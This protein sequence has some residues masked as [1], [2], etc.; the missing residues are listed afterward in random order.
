[1]FERAS[2]IN[3]TPGAM[4][5]ELRVAIRDRRGSMDVL[6]G[7]YMIQNK[8]GFRRFKPVLQFE[9]K[10]AGENL[11]QL[12]ADGEGVLLRI[13]GSSPADDRMP[14]SY[15]GLR[16]EG[17]PETGPSLAAGEPDFGDPYV[18]LLLAPPNKALRLEARAGI[19]PCGR[20]FAKLGPLS[21]VL[22]TVQEVDVPL[23]W[24]LP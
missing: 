24:G 7:N 17:Q 21:P 14:L 2:T 16:E 4:L 20:G 8:P 12:E 10:P 23:E 1:M 3:P 9:V 13:R 18:I 19:G 22:S 15:A 5:R 6:P 11:L